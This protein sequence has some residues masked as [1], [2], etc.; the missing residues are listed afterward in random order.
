MKT[1]L[2]ILT[3]AALIMYPFAAFSADY[4]SQSSQSQQAP[5]VAQTLV[6]EGDFAIKLAVKLNLGSPTDESSAETLLA[7]AGIVPLNGWLS[8][9]PV[10]P[11]IVGQIQAAIAQAASDNKLQMST[12][13]ATRGLY[14]LIAEENL[15]TPAGAGNMP[16]EAPQA[17]TAPSNPT[18]INNY[19][20]DQGPPIVT[21]YP[22]PTDYVYLYDWVPY[23]AFWFGFWFPGFYI[24]HTF[25][26]VVVRPPF[27]VGP[28]GRHVFVGGG[29]HLVTNH[30]FDP[31]T[32][33][34]V[35]VSPVTMTREGH[36]RPITT[37]R[38]GDGDRFR[39]FSDMHQR[40]AL[41]GL[42]DVTPGASMNRDPRITANNTPDAR[43]SA[44]D[45]YSRSIQGQRA[46][47]G[48]EG[49]IS[50]REV[51]RSSSPVARDRTY[52][53]A[54]SGGYRG[55]RP[56]ISSRS[57]E[58]QFYSPAYRNDGRV[59]MPS[60]R[61]GS[62]RGGSVTRTPSYRGGQGGRQVRG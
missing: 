6:R 14:S 40:T 10:T 46:N 43:K 32:R 24:C 36:V 48:P 1:L 45:I 39:S 59:G 50:N 17:A 60:Q 11:E 58:R 13:E 28:G 35:L 33:T 23:P 8:D 62:F 22:P 49:N 3:A 7:E 44:S 15:P 55:A 2:V 18:M 4:G 12:D 20:Y 29:R 52:Y 37:L 31:V 9:Y 19:Y 47:R 34:R 27:F 51:R 38:T 56:S 42:R 30:A 25:T 61:S 26:T 5:P 57:P 16:T 41:A 54:G 21:Y 53:G